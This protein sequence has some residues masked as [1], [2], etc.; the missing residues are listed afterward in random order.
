[1][2]D[3]RLRKNS[4]NSRD[5]RIRWAPATARTPETAGTPTT[6]GREATAGKHSSTGTPE[7]YSSKNIFNSKGQ[8]EH[9]AGTLSSVAC[10]I[11]D[12]S[13]RETS[14]TVGM[15]AIRELSWTCTKNMLKYHFVN[16]YFKKHKEGVQFYQY[17]V[18]CPL[19]TGISKI[20]CC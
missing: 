10:G 19:E 17:L 3:L 1:M 7:T 5:A 6:V 9:H 20:L 14:S 8:T 16:N 12:V 18:V 15:P 11:K 2:S 13:S 4:I